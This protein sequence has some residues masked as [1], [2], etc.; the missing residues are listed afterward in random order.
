MSF[1]AM[2]EILILQCR[3]ALQDCRTF[4]ESWHKSSTLLEW[5]HL[6]RFLKIALE[7]SSVLTPLHLCV[8][9]LHN[10]RQGIDNEVATAIPANMV[11]G[12]CNKTSSN[13][14]L[15]PTISPLPC[16]LLINSPRQPKS[17]SYITE[18]LFLFFFF[19]NE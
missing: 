5:K 4:R 3:I 1:V 12:C 10:Q 13:L 7:S 15:A 17:L 11:E 16:Q 19:L 2:A 9:G 14:C 18:M 6:I 8:K